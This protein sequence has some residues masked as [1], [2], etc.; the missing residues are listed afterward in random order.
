MHVLKAADYRRMPWKNGRGETREVAV[1]P[2][3]AGLD[4]L[5]WRISMAVVADSGPFS[6]FPGIDRTLC[7][8]EGK[9]LALDIGDDASPHRL[10]VDSAPLFFAADRPSS[11]APLDG[12]ILDLNVMTRRGQY[13]HDVRSIDGAASV[14]VDPQATCSWVIARHDGIRLIGS[15]GVKASLDRLDG[16]EIEAG[17][18][19]VEIRAAISTGAAWL[20]QIYALPAAA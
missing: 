12:P 7:I 14:E 16:A 9:G 10:T 11:G 13:R 2:R 1:H 20:I 8:L 4:T 6:L 15:D 18:A 5:G 3:D 17:D 19:P